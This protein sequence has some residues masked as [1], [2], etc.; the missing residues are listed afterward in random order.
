MP[1]IHQCMGSHK[2]SAQKSTLD[3]T[4]LM[5]RGRLKEARLEFAHRGWPVLPQGRRGQRILA[6]CAVQAW[7]AY[8]KNPEAAVRRICDELSPWL[9]DDRLVEL[10]AD[11]KVANKRFSHDQC[12]MV[13]EIS[14]SDCLARGYRFLGASDDWS[15]EARHKAKRARNAA[16]QRRRRAANGAVPRAV[17]EAN[18][19][20]KTEPW[21]QDG[22]GCRRTW[23]RWRKKA[24]AQ[25]GTDVASPS[26]DKIRVTGEVTHLRNEASMRGAP[27]ASPRQ[28]EAIH[29]DDGRDALDARPAPP[30]NSLIVVP[31]DA[32]ILEGEII[33]GG[34]TR[35]SRPKMPKMNRH[36]LSALARA[37]AIQREEG[38]R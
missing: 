31:P 2:R 8:P 7:L 17:Y 4:V 36:V 14:V 23:E 24:A 9:K 35:D 3:K 19:I 12:A 21:K 6:W 18:S 29:G 11:T 27:Q 25:A 38:R 16:C 5:A 15:Y 10:I 13:L 22:F 30:S 34:R 33:T 26:P 28:H 32:V 37:Y 20:S 1:T